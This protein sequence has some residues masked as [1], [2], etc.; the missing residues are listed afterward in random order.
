MAHFS[1]YAIQHNYL[2]LDSNRTMSYVQ[3][4]RKGRLPAEGSVEK[5]SGDLVSG[6]LSNY[7]RG[8]ISKQVMEYVTVEFL[9]IER[10]DSRSSTIFCLFFLQSQK[11][12]V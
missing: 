1:N 8:Q 12:I 2:L 9:E 10:L 6:T 3:Y 7:S 11:T 4:M 5:H